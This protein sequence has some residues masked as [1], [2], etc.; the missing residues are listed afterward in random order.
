M[1]AIQNEAKRFWPDLAEDQHIQ[2]RGAAQPHPE[3]LHLSRRPR[4]KGLATTFIQVIETCW[5]NQQRGG[6]QAAVR[7][8]VPMIFRTPVGDPA[9]PVLLHRALCSEADGFSPQVEAE[10]QRLSAELAAQYRVAVHPEAHGVRVEFFGE[11]SCPAS[12]SATASDSVVLSPGMWLRIVANRRVAV[13]DTCT[14]H[15]FVYNIAHCEPADVNSLFA[16][17]A[18]VLC[19]NRETRLL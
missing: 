19:I 1:G 18:P 11:P 9:A 8:A 16:G 17:S 6:S 7:N 14:Y 12:A 4:S 5:S 2:A 15:R 3:R 13:A 10:V